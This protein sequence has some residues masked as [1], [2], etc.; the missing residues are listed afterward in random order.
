M[1]SSL[2]RALRD[3]PTVLILGVL[4]VAIAFLTGQA[5]AHFGLVPFVSPFF[6]PLV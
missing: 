2:I 5:T 4:C 3:N 1:F 6:S